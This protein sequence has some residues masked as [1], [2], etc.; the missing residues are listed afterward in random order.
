M[1]TRQENAATV[2]A[3]GLAVA[4][5]PHERHAEGTLAIKAS[6][7]YSETGGITI[8]V[9]SKDIAAVAAEVAKLSE[10]LVPEMCLQLSE[11][12]ISGGAG[13]WNQV[14]F[15]KHGADAD[16]EERMR[17]VCDKLGL[18]HNATWRHIS[19]RLES[20]LECRAKWLAHQEEE[21]RSAARRK[22][23][24]ATAKF[25]TQEIELCTK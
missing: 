2:A 14:R 18:P 12:R 9:Q 8:V 15:Y 23:E 21:E 13:G 22:L 3:N 10:L 1:A 4:S 5:A 20:A 19:V 25:S 24:V 11:W 6:K 7:T 16:E 17:R